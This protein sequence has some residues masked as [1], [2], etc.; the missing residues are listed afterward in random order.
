[1]NQ[2]RNKA[3]FT[4]QNISEQICE[5]IFLWVDFD[6]REQPGMDI[7]TGGSVIMDYGPAL[8]QKN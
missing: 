6:V 4:S 8:P 7:F 5:W 2:E 1:M 3:L